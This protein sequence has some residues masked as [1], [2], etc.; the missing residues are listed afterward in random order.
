[1]QESGENETL[2]GGDDA[3]RARDLRQAA[4]AN[5]EGPEEAGGVADPPWKVRIQRPAVWKKAGALTFEAENV[6]VPPAKPEHLRHL[7]ELT[8]ERELGEQQPV[9]HEH[10]AVDTGALEG[11]DAEQPVDHVPGRH[12]FDPAPQ[13]DPPVGD[14]AGVE[15]PWTPLQHLAVHADAPVERVGQHDLRVRVERVD[16]LLEPARVPEIVIARPREIL[17]VGMALARGIERPVRVADQPEPLAVALVGD[18]RVERGV[19]PRD[20]GGLVRR[21]VVDQHQREIRE[22]LIEDRLDRLGKVPGVIEERRSDDDARHSAACPVMHF[23]R[24]IF[25]RFQPITCL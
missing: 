16:Q 1:V 2:H 19:L 17:R 12:V 14:A 13:T 15:R 20:G 24:Q 4:P 21:A 22:G 18:A 8:V 6:S 10:V 7:L 5:G 25:I 9:R 11:T 3:R 23:P